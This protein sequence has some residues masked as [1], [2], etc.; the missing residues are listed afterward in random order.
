M[1]ASSEALSARAIDILAKLVAF[2]TTSRRS[3]LALIE[4]VEQYL[5]ELNV[6]TRRVPNADGTKS[7]LMAMIGPAV[8]GGVVLS[9]HTDVV[10]VDGQPWSTDPWTL[11]E[12]DGRLYGRG[13]CD[14][15]GF[16]ALALAAAPDLAQANLRKPV[17]LAFSYDEEVGCLGA[18]DM[19]DVIA[20]EVPRPALVVVGEPTDMV[21]VRAHK[22]IA[23]F[24]VTVTGREA[25]SSL[26]HLGVSANMVA[27]KL[28]AMLVGLSEKLEREADPNSPFTPKGATLTIGQ[29]NGGTAVNILARECV[30]IFDLRTPAGMDP[31]ALLS[32]F[33]AMASALD[34]EIKAKAPEGGV[35][36]ER[37]SLTPAFAPEEDGVAEAFAR[38]LAGDNGPARVVPY[39]AEAG[40]FQGAGFSTVI[41]GPGSID[42]A[43]QPNEYVEISQMQRGGAFMRRLVEDLSTS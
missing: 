33:F 42:Q 35:K 21:A 11:T 28:M 7:N 40:Q 15:K 26:T 5:A 25:H 18:P 27:I 24:K 38:K 16:L 31:V 32:D 37:R 1:V 8:E 17:H 34:A 30:F 13:T 41:C 39:A 3:N 10:P 14:M 36:V 43:H 29:V 22:G 2:D 20:R 4:W 6:P 12:R 9:G 23:S 19:I